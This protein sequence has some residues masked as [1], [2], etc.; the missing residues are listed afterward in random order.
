MEVGSHSTPIWFEFPALSF[1]HFQAPWI[2]SNRPPKDWPTKGA[3]DFDQ[4]EL[5]YRP[6]LDLV[7]K[8]LDWHIDSHEKVGV[9]GRTG[10]GKSSTT[11]ALFRIVEPAGGKIVIDDIDISAIGLHDL[12]SRLAIIPQDPILFSGTLRNNLDPFDEHEDIRVWA[13]L[14]QAHLKSFIAQLSGGLQYQVTEG[15]ENLR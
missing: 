10:A 11:L 6:G 9:V 1:T 13:A 8:G 7:L 4:L 5:R 2:T 14:E 12:R 15:G 3:I